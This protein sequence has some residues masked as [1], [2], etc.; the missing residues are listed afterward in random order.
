VNKVYKPRKTKANVV[1]GKKEQKES[2][3]SREAKQQ[4]IQKVLISTTK[5]YAQVHRE[6]VPQRSQVRDSTEKHETTE[7]VRGCLRRKQNS[8]KNMTETVK[9]N[10]WMQPSKQCKR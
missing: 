7:N 2:Q 3:V 8:G 6:Q 9:K 1:R 4:R 10:E 5:G